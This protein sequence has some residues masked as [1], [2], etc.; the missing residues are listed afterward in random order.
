MF[1]IYFNYQ[2]QSHDY[3]LTRPAHLAC[4]MMKV[5]TRSRPDGGA[6][7]KIQA[8][9]WRDAR[10]RTAE[11]KTAPDS[12]LPG[13]A[14]SEGGGL[15]TAVDIQERY[16]TAGGRGQAAIPFFYGFRLVF[17][18]PQAQQFGRHLLALQGQ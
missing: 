10:R 9:D 5:S 18:F 13:A 17:G 11:M 12:I 15:F 7:T 2:R 6:D 3:H 16:R 4:P 1:I 8:P 14:G